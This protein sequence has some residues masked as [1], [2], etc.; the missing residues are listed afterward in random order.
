MT[1]TDAKTYKLEVALMGCIPSHP[2]IAR[3]LGYFD[4]PVGYALKYYHGSLVEIIYQEDKWPALSQTLIRSLITDVAKGLAHLHKSGIVHFDI[5]P[6]NILYETR[7]GLEIPIFV[8]SDF[9]VSS[10]SIKLQIPKLMYKV[11]CSTCWVRYVIQQ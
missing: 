8:I 9:G 7:P 3:F 10:R 2:N 11:V 6:G 1:G 5:K 4:N